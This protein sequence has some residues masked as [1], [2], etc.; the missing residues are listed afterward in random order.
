MNAAVGG[1]FDFRWTADTIPDGVFAHDIPAL[2]ARYVNGLHVEGFDV[3]WADA[4]P[5]W[6]SSALELENTSNVLID[7]FTGRQASASSTFPVIAAKHVSGISITNSRADRR[8]STFFSASDVIGER[9]FS[10]NDLSDARQPFDS[11]T[12]F[13][14]GDNIL[15][16]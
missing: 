5:A 11:A 7:H 3:R 1:N 13:V 4:M 12:S 10:G 14:M 8:A 9:L 16:H 6:Y 2:Y 15:K